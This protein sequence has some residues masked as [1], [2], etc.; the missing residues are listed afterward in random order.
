MPLAPEIAA[1]LA[2]LAADE[3]SQRPTETDLAGA[4]ASHEHDAAA[5]SPPRTRAEVGA[6]EMTRF[7]GPGGP[8]PVRIY[9]PRLEDTA[10]LIPV[11]LWFHGGG[12]TTGS[13]ETGDILARA[14]CHHTPAA[15]V[16]VDYR[17]AP[18]H[19]WPAA[20]DDA[21]AALGWLSEH[22][23]E[24]GG[25]PSRLAVGGDS[26]GGNIAAAV[27]HAARDGD[28]DLAA[29]ILVYPFLDLDAANEP[30]YP[31]MSRNA[32]DYYVTL[33][34]LHWCVSNYVRAGAD[35]A[36]HRVSPLRDDAFA[37][38]PATVLA[39]AEF[40]PL[41]DQGLAYAARLR[42]AGV[43]V[44]GHSGAGLIHGYGDMSGTS[45]TAQQELRRLLAS[46]VETLGVA[47]PS[48]R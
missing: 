16:A 40:D 32:K 11:V 44:I 22:L 17:L 24:L 45:I 43:P 47:R 19:P 10:T 9:R 31:S 6:V 5:F 38:L 18:E 7:P 8:V 1:I 35:P 41:A 3:T 4:R 34:D 23:G 48:I 42:D 2:Q 33:A 21:L 26:A 12:W 29:Q 20:T 15:V 27:A 25:D 13:L 37:G 14:V 36:D 28:I 46:V 39:T 30:A